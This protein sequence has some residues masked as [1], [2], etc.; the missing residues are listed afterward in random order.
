MRRV[1]A[2][3]FDLDGVLV[4]SREAT[5]RVWLAWAAENG[6]EEDALRSAMHGV[7]SADV[8]RALRPDLD[9]VV[10]SDEI[11]RRQAVDVDGLRADPRCRC[12]APGIEG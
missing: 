7:R 4:E 1:S 10:E 6:I 2:V 9:A 12:G 3:L 5:E 8:V 11:E